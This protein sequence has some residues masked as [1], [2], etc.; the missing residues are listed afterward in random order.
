[1]DAGIV[2]RITTHCT[3][4][5]LV[6]TKFHQYATSAKVSS[7]CI[8][9]L[10]YTVPSLRVSV[11]EMQLQTEE[12][13]FCDPYERSCQVRLNLRAFYGTVQALRFRATAEV[14][15]AYAFRA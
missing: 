1:M 4:S 10:D 12:E 9:S 3:C 11:L 5:N 2:T 8:F 14:M 6:A 7:L 15:L 13:E